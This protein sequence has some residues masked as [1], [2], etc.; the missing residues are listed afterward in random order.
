MKG[1]DFTNKSIIIS[2]A[3]GIGAATAK[4]L[5][6]LGAQIILID[7]NEQ[8]MDS[9][10]DSLIGDSNKCYV[11]DFSIVEGIEPIIKTIVKDNGPIDGFVHC[12]GTGAVRPLKMSK[13]DF[14]L[15]VMN[16]NF[17]SFVELARCL[18]AK[19][20]FN[21]KGMNMVGI[22]AVGAFIGNST[23]TAYCASKGAMNAAIRC[24]AKELAQK[25]IRVNAIAPGTTDT[26]MAREA[27]IYR[28]G[29][30]EQQINELRQYLGTC[31]PED[32][33]DAVAFLLSDMSLKI[34]G[35]CLPVD[36]GKLSS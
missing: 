28:E 2:G 4:L 31:Q 36:G 7:I 3:G 18:S 1:L 25:K 35:T 30:D 13:Y 33:A 12:V 32:I 14:M 29:T 15:K 26:L 11:C 17:F 34:T 20:N 5:N 19:G 9:T 16:I 27:L 22:S 21:P 24:M 23:K 6:S 10:L 8:N